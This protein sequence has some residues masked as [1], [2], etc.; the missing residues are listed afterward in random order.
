M[1]IN[2]CGVPKTVA[3][4]V[5]FEEIHQVAVKNKDKEDKFKTW[6]NETSACNGRKDLVCI[7][8][9]QATYRDF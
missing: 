4:N 2:D 3:F 5:A 6:N 1:D 7:L 8:G 9:P